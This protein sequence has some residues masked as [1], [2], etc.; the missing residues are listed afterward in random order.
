MVQDLR[1]GAVHRSAHQ[2]LDR[3]Q[4]DLADLAN[5]GKNDLKQAAYFLCDLVLD[6]LGRFFSCGVNVSSI[7]RMRHSC[8]LT[9]TNA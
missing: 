7:G 3:L 2:H 4:I 1:S 8:S 6:R 9:C 5:S